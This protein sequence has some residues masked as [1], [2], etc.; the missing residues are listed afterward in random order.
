MKESEEWEGGE[1]SNVPTYLPLLS[2]EE[3]NI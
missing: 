3:V 2:F 1:R